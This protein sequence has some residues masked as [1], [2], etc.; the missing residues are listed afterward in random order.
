MNSIIK[1]IN[2]LKNLKEIVIKLSY[3]KLFEDKLKL[4]WSNLIIKFQIYLLINN[5]F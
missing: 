1:N 4:I 5:I 3:L 2:Y